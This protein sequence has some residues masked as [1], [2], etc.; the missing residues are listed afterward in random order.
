MNGKPGEK[1]IAERDFRSQISNLRFHIQI[2]RL[3]FQIADNWG[4]QISAA[5]F[6]VDVCEASMG[7][8]SDAI[9]AGRLREIHRA[10]SHFD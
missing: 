7:K 9:S 10:I 8:R 4:F 3:K 2:C 6:R 1:V 5:S